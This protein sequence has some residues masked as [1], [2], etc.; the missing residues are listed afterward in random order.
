M[1][2]QISSRVRAIASEICESDCIPG[3]LDDATTLNLATAEN[4]LIRKELAEL[5]RGL[6]QNHLDSSTLSYGKGFGGDPELL[7]ATAAIFNNYFN[8]A[9]P[10]CP[11]DVVI[12]T[13]ASLCL[14]ALMYSLCEVGDEVLITA[15]YWIQITLTFGKF[16][17]A[18]PHHHN[19][20][21]FDK[22]LVLRTGVKL[23]PIYEPSADIGLTPLEDLLKGSLVP[24]LTQAYESSA[25]PSRVK[26]LVITNSHN[27]YGRYYPE[28][29]IREAMLWCGERGVHYVSD[30]VYALSELMAPEEGLRDGDQNIRE[31]PTSSLFVSALSVRFEGDEPDVNNP[32]R[33][34]IGPRVD[35]VPEISVI[36]GTSKDL[37]SSGLRVGVYVHRQAPASASRLVTATTGAPASNPLVSIPVDRS[38][39]TTVLSNLTTSHLPTLTTSLLTKELF[40]SPLLRELFPLARTRL[41]ENYLLLRDH[42]QKWDVPYVEVQGAP[43]VLARLACAVA[44][45]IGNGK[46]STKGRGEVMGCSCTWE[47]EEFLVKLLRDRAGVLV[48]PGRQYH[49]ANE[50]DSGMS[51]GSDGQGEPDNKRA[52]WVRITFGVPRPTLVKAIARISAVLGLEGQVTV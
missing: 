25:D 22:H 27:P 52:G 20:D 32:S 19:L 50:T 42:L 35:K 48:A 10:V 28:S 6:V 1:T 9:H 14:D 29:V 5:Y 31:K 46:L 47:D 44:R 26:A 39:L 23:L 40:K 17:G 49:I 4:W 34:S 7:E 36:W 41:R 8:P 18:N 45:G 43:F 16:K 51:S 13:G 2:F 15:P 21:G 38:P 11:D 30:E 12:T 24:A 3:Y 33:G 37:C